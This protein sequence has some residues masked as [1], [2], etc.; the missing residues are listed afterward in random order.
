MARIG[1]P[2][3]YNNCLDLAAAC[4]M[5]FEQQDEKEKPYTVPGLAVAIG[6]ASRQSILEYRHK[7]QFADT[8]KAALARIEAQRNEQLLT[9]PHAA[10][11]IFDLKNNFG[12]KDKTEVETTVNTTVTIGLS[13]DFR[14]RIEALKGTG[15]GQIEA[16]V[17]DAV[18][19]P[20]NDKEIERSSG[21]D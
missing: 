3:L 17:I 9:S 16:R 18:A 12:W 8:L 15:Q 10:G 14:S 11:K 5:Y 6:F 20:Q 19:I 13:D 2:P 7:D 21:D 1:R 4:E